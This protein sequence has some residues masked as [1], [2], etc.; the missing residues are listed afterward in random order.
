MS[1]DSFEVTEA[2]PARSQLQRRELGPVV[3]VLG[4]LVYDRLL[5][6]VNGQP[7]HLDPVTTIPDLHAFFLHREMPL[8]LA[9]EELYT[10]AD[11]QDAMTQVDAFVLETASHPEGS[12]THYIDSKK[13][14]HEGLSTGIHFPINIALRAARI[15]EMPEVS[16][17]VFEVGFIPDFL[18]R[19]DIRELIIKMAHAPNGTYESPVSSK[20]VNFEQG[21]TWSHPRRAVMIAYDKGR[22]EFSLS[23]SGK[24]FLKELR[25]SANQRPVS[26][27]NQS[28]GCPVRYSGFPVLGE[29]ATKFFDEFDFEPPQP[30]APTLIEKGMDVAARLIELGLQSS[31]EE[32]E[33]ES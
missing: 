30:G 33:Q 20:I 11:T 4:D 24:Q 2:L 3:H 28:G 12:L 14:L 32:G 29:F 8:L 15:A 16:R 1:T 7:G 31:R 22:D 10:N 25:E 23:A 5:D 27:R 21:V 19:R 26:W 17:D 9:L 18:H 6:T 13:V